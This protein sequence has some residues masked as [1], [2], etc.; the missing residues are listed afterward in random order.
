MINPFARKRV[1]SNQQRWFLVGYRW[2]LPFLMVVIAQHIVQYQGTAV[3]W[4]KAP[5]LGV[6]MAFWLTAL[7]RPAWAMRVDVPVISL[8]AWFLLAAGLFLLGTP[9]P[10]D[11][12]ILLRELAFWIPVICAYWTMHLYSRPWL[13][14]ALLVPFV[15]GLIWAETHVHALAL[16]PILPGTSFQVVT[17]TIILVVMVR[18]F[19]AIHASLTDQRDRAR[20]KALRDDL[21]GLHNR[22]AFEHELRRTVRLA[23]RYNAPFSLVV[24]DIDHFKSFNDRFGHLAGDA[25]LRSAARTFR[26]TL[27]QSDLISRWGGEEFAV[28]LPNTAA[29]EA[30]HIAN[31]LR[32]HMAAQPPSSGDRVTISCG[33]ATH[34]EHDTPRAIF[35]RADAA[36]LEAKRT[37]RNRVIC[38]EQCP[39]VPDDGQATLSPL[40]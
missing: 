1:L 29:P 24:M 22:F 30:C 34:L 23:Q 17:Q 10:T 7:A 4:A 16:A 6:L 15:S 20:K 27:R 32:L 3:A 36:L 40:K 12:A 35:E 28:I 9:T 19:G 2:A 14:S 26:R 25:V 13:T 21:T 8:V 37:G 39:N 18:V 33:V 38:S 31:K 5:A 11:G